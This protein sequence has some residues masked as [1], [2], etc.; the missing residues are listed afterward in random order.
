[1]T[2]LSIKRVLDPNFE[3]LWTNKTLYEQNLR[4]GGR[5]GS[6]IEPYTKDETLMTAIS[7]QLNDLELN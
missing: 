7:R 4:L 3:A 6:K 2:A 5:N 1:M